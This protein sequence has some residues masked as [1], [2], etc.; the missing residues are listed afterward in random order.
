[1]IVYDVLIRKEQ[2]RKPPHYVHMSQ[3]RNGLDVLQFLLDLV[4]HIAGYTHKFYDE[5]EGKMNHEELV[6][7]YRAERDKYIDKINES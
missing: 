7:K 2:E 5:I 3:F 4:N 6:T 1:M